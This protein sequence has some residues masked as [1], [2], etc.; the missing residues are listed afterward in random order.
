MDATTNEIENLQT[1]PVAELHQRFA[2]VRR[3]ANQPEPHLPR[4]QDRA[5]RR[6]GRRPGAAEGPCA[7]EGGDEGGQGHTGGDEGR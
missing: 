2:A 6:Y 7:Q 1:L 4:P 3:Q 5:P